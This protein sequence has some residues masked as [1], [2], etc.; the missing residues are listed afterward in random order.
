MRLIKPADL[1]TT[2]D[3]PVKLSLIEGLEKD[4]DCGLTVRALP[5]GLE[6]DSE[7]GVISGAVKRAGIYKITATARDE[8]GK[9]TSVTFTMTVGALRAYRFALDL[10]ETQ[11]A[12][13]RQHAGAARWAYNFALDRK[14]RTHAAYTARRQALLDAG[15][16]A[17]QAKAALKTES[18]ALKAETAVWDHHRQCLFKLKTGKDLP[19]TPKGPQDLIDRLAAIR[20]SLPTPPAPELLEYANAWKRDTKEPLPAALEWARARQATYMQALE[21]RLVTARAI[22]AQLKKQLFDSGDT[23][24]GFMD[25]MAV[26]R[27]IRDLPKEEGG[28]PWHPEVSSYAISCGVE[29]AERAWKNWMESFAGKRAGAR[30]GYPRF[31]AKGRSEDS[32][33]LYHDVNTPSIRL[34]GYRHINMPRIGEV[35]VHNSGHRAGVR[36]REGRMQ[37]RGRQGSTKRLV[38][39]IERGD[40]VVQSVAVTRGGHRWYANVLVKLT[41]EAMRQ[42]ESVARSHQKVSKQKAHARGDVGVEW[43]V[44]TLATLSNGE[45]F[46]NPRPYKKN[47][48]RLRKASQAV[49]RKPYTR[50]QASSAN[51]RKAID[52]LGKVH[53]KIAETRKGHLHQVSA[54]ISLG[55][56]SVA[57]R[58]L[59]V[60]RMTKSAKGTREKPGRNVKVQATF[61]RAVLDAAPGTFKTMLA[62]KTA[63]YGTK[64]GVAPIDL[65]SSQTCSACGWRDPSIP[66]EQLTFRCGQCGKEIDREVNAARN[67]RDAVAVDLRQAGHVNT[68]CGEGVRPE[69]NRGQPPLKQ[70]DLNPHPPPEDGSGA[71]HFRDESPGRSRHS[72]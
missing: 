2:T 6:L 60:K 57:V 40:A 47:Q 27:Q 44:R 26:W 34:E 7:T 36:K 24:P 38:R 5:A 1:E 58:D 66:L 62:S 43:G 67:I 69:G 37:G 10:T 53:H 63:Q 59:S 54:A 20:A 30:V 68:A 25:L 8:S 23:I 4:A 45:T 28:S 33:R 16:T 56:R 39:M 9:K 55:Y 46:P 70:E 71:G 41:P 32:F 15:M 12:S 50:G 52:R 18:A 13:L 65:P 11:E 51:R 19:K 35:R 31:K 22:V 49:S 21:E 17:E 3:A 48:Q 61:N 72:S 64:F 14:V 42:R 29:N